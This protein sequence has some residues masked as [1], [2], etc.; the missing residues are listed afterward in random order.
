MPGSG[1]DV[2]ESKPM[3]TSPRHA[4]SPSDLLA[5]PHGPLGGRRSEARPALPGRR[6]AVLSLTLTVLAGLIIGATFGAA[7]AALSAAGLPGLAALSPQASLLALGALVGGLTALLAAA[8][9]GS[10]VRKLLQGGSQISNRRGAQPDQS[11]EPMSL[12]GDK[13]AAAS[14]A[15]PAAAKP[16]AAMSID[17]AADIRDTLTGAFTQRYFLAAADREWSRIRRHGEDAALLMI[18]ADQLQS[19]NQ[20][21]GQ[22]CGDA[23]LV[24]LTRLVG[25]TL[26]EYDLMARFNA[27][28]LVVYLPHTD[29]IGAID[30]AERIRDRIASF[31]LNWPSGTVTVTV[32]VG[33]AAVGADHATLDTVIGDAGAALREAKL[34]G[35]NCVRAAP[36]PP[37]RAPANGSA[38]GDRRTTGPR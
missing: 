4:S 13:A 5:R 22:E 9:G 20:A 18:D 7:V 8:L 36:V 23:M 38:R 6:S 11:A 29:P 27:G 34:A 37:K 1:H 14:L 28:V 19:I 25:G 31:R 16:A 15:S 26:R 24:H 32:S 2:L 21:H 3:D 33:V 12:P 17:E 30:V 10:L 35:R